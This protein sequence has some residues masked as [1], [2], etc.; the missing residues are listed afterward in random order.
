M[1]LRPVVRVLRLDR[2]GG[3]GRAQAIA[4]VAGAAFRVLRARVSVLVVR[5]KDVLPQVPSLAVVAV[6]VVVRGCAQRRGC[7]A[8]HRE[9]WVGAKR[10]RVHRRRRRGHLLRRFAVVVFP[11]GATLLPRISLRGVSPRRR[12]TAPATMVAGRV[13]GLRPRA[14][15]SPAVL[16]CIIR[17]PGVFRPP[18]PLHCRLSLP[19]LPLHDFADLLRRAFSRRACRA[20]PNVCGPCHARAARL[21]LV[22][23]RRCDTVSKIARRLP[24]RSHARPCRLSVAAARQRV[25]RMCGPG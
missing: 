8:V 16:R 2:R 18:F 24:P 21:R 5:R 7:D 12:G 19:R 17:R 4:R 11:R 14:A 6:I 13:R 20:S 9:T 3:G 23:R 10:R 25:L 15:M 22:V 1:D